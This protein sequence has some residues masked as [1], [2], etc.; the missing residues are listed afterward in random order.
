MLPR[1]SRPQVRGSMAPPRYH[2]HR[3]TTR[4]PEARTRRTCGPDKREVGYQ[5]HTH[6]TQSASRQR[7]S[8]RRLP[9]KRNCFS[10]SDST[11]RSGGGSSYHLAMQS[12]R[13]KRKFCASIFVKAGLHRSCSVFP[14]NVFSRI[15][16]AP[17]KLNSSRPG[18]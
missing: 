17:R 11:A 5:P 15:Q 18:R 16:S 2:L 3:H 1:R 8:P 12:D 13:D 9:E 6:E 14:S 7:L 10:R 4:Q